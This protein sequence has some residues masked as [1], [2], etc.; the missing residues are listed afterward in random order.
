[1]PVLSQFWL[2]PVIVS[3]NCLDELS[4]NGIKIDDSTWLMSA[5]IEHNVLNTIRG[6]GIVM[7]VESRV[8]NL[9]ILGNELTNIGAS[10]SKA[11]IAGIYLTGV[12]EGAVSDNYIQ[13]VGTN[14]LDA[15]VITGV[16]IDVCNAMRISDNTIMNIGPAS[17]HSAESASIF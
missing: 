15:N 6:N 4:E 14:S 7:G 16:R 5:L 3:G 2:G 1:N 11:D 8:G 10:D 12:S 9:K 13:D 17:N